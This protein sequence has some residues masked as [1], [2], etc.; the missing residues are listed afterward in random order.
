MN[1]RANTSSFKPHLHFI[2][3]VDVYS[4]VCHEEPDV[5]KV[6]P[7]CSLQISVTILIVYTLTVTFL[8]ERDLFWLLKGYFLF[9]AFYR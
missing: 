2:S 7:V 4:K 3:V 1:E 9:T 8:N 6:G 5:A